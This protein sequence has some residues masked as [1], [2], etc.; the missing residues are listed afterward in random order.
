MKTKKRLLATLLTLAMVFSMLPMGALAE[1]AVQNPP[2]EVVGPQTPGAVPPETPAEP[3][4][5][6]PAETPVE[7]PVENPA[8]NPVE[9]PV[10]PPVV[11]VGPQDPG[12]GPRVTV[13]TLSGATDSAKNIAYNTFGEAVAAINGATAADA[14]V[15]FTITLTAS[16]S[17]ATTMPNKKVTIKSTEINLANAPTLTVTA[18]LVTNGSTTTH[19]ENLNLLDTATNSDIMHAYGTVSIENCTVTSTSTEPLLNVPGTLSLDNVTVKNNGTGS[20]IFTHDQTITIKN[21]SIT[22]KIALGTGK[23]VLQDVPKTVYNVE[24]S[25]TA[26]EIIATAV[27]INAS[28]AAAKIIVNGNAGW[29]AAASGS[30]IVLK[31]LPIRYVKS[32]GSDSA[33]NDGSAAKPYLTIGKAYSALTDGGEIRVL[34]NLTAD[35]ATTFN[36]NKTVTVTSYTDATTESTLGGHTIT[37]GTGFKTTMLGITKGDVTLKHIT[38]D[39]A[40]DS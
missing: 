10:E 20:A 25:K 27:G 9:T 5:E 6:N 15:G 32:D 21:S 33:P 4:V 40:G 17:H 13:C 22:E 28:D 35:A 16:C 31:Y 2:A 8:E 38:L 12:A 39:G 36:A 23:L 34:S 30:N 26:G 11:Q 3:P 29:S 19:F 14:N 37:R 24:T 7:P 1:E 18:F